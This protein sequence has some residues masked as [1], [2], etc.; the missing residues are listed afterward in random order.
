MPKY[1]LFDADGTDLGEMRLGDATW[2]PGDEIFMGPGKTL[3]II[4]GRASYPD[5]AGDQ[6]I[7]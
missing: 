1:R 5:T 7:I 6:R 2:K 4:V 3:R